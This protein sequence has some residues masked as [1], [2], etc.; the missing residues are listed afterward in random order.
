M[1]ELFLVNKNKNKNKGS[2]IYKYSEEYWDELS[3]VIVKNS[4]TIIERFLPHLPLDA[5]FSYKNDEWTGR[6]KHE[7]KVER[8]CVEIIKKSDFSDYKRRYK[9][10]LGKI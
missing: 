2:Q 10:V 5:K 6:D 3:D 8:A 4:K 9:M 1:I 7:M